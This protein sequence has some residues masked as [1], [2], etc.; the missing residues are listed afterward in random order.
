MSGGKTEPATRAGPTGTRPA[1]ATPAA[2]VAHAEPDPEAASVALDLANFVQSPGEQ[3]FTITNSSRF[4]VDLDDWSVVTKSSGSERIGF[5]RGLVLA[6]GTSLTVHTQTGTNSP[7]DV[8]LGLPA[9]VAPHVYTPG[10]PAT[11][12]IDIV[13]NDGPQYFRYLLPAASSDR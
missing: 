13:A 8:Y 7:A 12:F 11:G 2:P 5:A 10:D 3:T 9:D 6:P 4:E 1:T